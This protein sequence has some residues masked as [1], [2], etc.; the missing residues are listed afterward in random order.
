[1]KNSGS[2]HS[3]TSQADQVAHRRRPA[4][5]AAIRRAI[6]EMQAMEAD[7]RAAIAA[8]PAEQ[9]VLP[10]VLSRLCD[11]ESCTPG[12][13]VAWGQDVNSDVCRD[14][15]LARDSLRD[16]AAK[17]ENW[18]KI[19]RAFELAEEIMGYFDAQCPEYTEA[20]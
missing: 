15:L 20:S 16:L 14:A 2:T 3:S 10:A 18:Q 1:M 4:P 5:P 6:T 19:K 13:V 12:S 7:I 9:R 8:L 17:D 11:L